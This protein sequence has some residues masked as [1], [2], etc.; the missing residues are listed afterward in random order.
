MTKKIKK[1]LKP[2]VAFSLLCWQAPLWASGFAI[3]ENSA[4]GVGNAFAGAAAVGE[5]ASTIWFNPAAMSRLGEH[6]D[7]SSSVHL[8]LPSAKFT[9]RGSSV[10]PNL[11][12]GSDPTIPLAGQ[13]N[14]TADKAAIVPNFFYVRPINER[15]HFGI[16]VNAPFGLEVT[17]QDNW[18]GRYL[19]TRSE[20]QT[21]NINPS[22]SW[23]AN[24]RLSVGAG[25]NAQY[26]N[27]KLGSAIDSGALCRRSASDLN[28]GGL[29]L[30]CLTNPQLGLANAAS[31]SSVLISG[32]DISYGYNLGVLLDANEHTRVGISYRSKMSHNVTG[33]ADFSVNDALSGVTLSN[34]TPLNLALGATA[35]KDREVHATADL[36]DSASFSVAHQL[37]NR[38][39]LLADATWTGWSSFK[40]LRVVD[41][42]GS[43]VALTTEDWEDVWR[44][45]IGG[46]YQYTDRLTLRAGAALDQSPIPNANLRTPRIPG[47]DRHWLSFGADYKIRDTIKINVGYAHLFVDDTAINHTSSDNGY[48]IK[49]L[50]E[51]DVDVLS[52]QL[53]WKY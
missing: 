7:I 30:S 19:A 43:D 52:A 18:I 33:T 42:T 5:D 50:Y 36:P 44:F 9:D 32:D 21:I 37:N 48:T 6:P 23:K 3:V 17:Y 45:S 27:V 1:L 24:K 13:P 8:I 14:D 34:G 25:L 29:L 26:V 15:M 11:T 10:N 38:F 49:G 4:S 35:L 41:N 46:K 47:N 53:D 22:I 51:S 12:P 40:E 28:D 2:A 39:E 20:M 31:D 16:G